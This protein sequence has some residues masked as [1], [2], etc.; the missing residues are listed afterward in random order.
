MN[1]SYCCFLRCPSNVFQRISCSGDEEEPH[2]HS[3]SAITTKT[4]FSDHLRLSLLAGGLI[5]AFSALAARAHDMLLSQY[6]KQGIKIYLKPAASPQSMNL[7]RRFLC[8]PGL[9][10]G[11]ALTAW[12]MRI[13]THEYKG[14]KS[15]KL[16][17]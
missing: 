11:D 17:H 12:I 3:F 14:S 13:R 16:H 15:T 7:E 8:E 9:P 6:K 1:T 2:P 5:T 10:L 4:S